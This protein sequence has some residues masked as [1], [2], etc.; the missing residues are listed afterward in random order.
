MIVM[1]LI[2]RYTN[3][4]K[5]VVSFISFVAVL[6]A[7]NMFFIKWGLSFL[8]GNTHASML[9]HTGRID[10]ENFMSSREALQ[11]NET[12]HPDKNRS[13]NNSPHIGT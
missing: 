2:G 3:L 11:N 10:K 12:T 8:V 13:I 1:R 5:V 4:Q 7:L 9:I 6:Y